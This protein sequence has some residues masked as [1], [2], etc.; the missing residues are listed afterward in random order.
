MKILFAASECAPFVKVGGLADV[1]GSLPRAL[2][3]LGADVSIV[4]PYYGAIKLD[5]KPNLVKKNIALRFE[6]KEA[7]FNL[8]QTELPKTNVSVFLIENSDYFEKGG[9]YIENDASSG[10]SI[11]EARRFLFFSLASVK[12]AN[13]INAN[14]LH[15]HDWHTGLIPY[16]VKKDDFPLKTIISIHNIGYQGVYPSQT[17]NLL[18]KTNFGGSVNCL[19][20]GIINA[21]L[22]TTV[23]Q[24]YAQEILT[25]EF[26][27]GLENDLKSRKKDLVGILNGLDPDQFN[28]QK[29]I[30]IKREFSLKNFKGKIENKIH[31][32]KICFQKTDVS[33]P[34]VG[35]VSRLAQQKGFDLIKEIFPKLMDAKMQ[36][37]I[38][39]EGIKE[40]QDFLQSM[41]PKF[42]DKFFVKIGFDEKFAHQIY[43]GSDI[44]LMPS[45]YEPCG[46]GQMI[47][48]RYGAVPIVRS[49]GGLKDTVKSV[50][51]KTKS[52]KQAI[53][54]TGFLFKEYKGQKLL[55]AVKKALKTFENKKIWIQVQK[56]AMKQDFSWRQSAKKYLEIYQRLTS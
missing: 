29:N 34:I 21:D 41:A 3:E 9:V 44:F 4:L 5:R 56:N 49:V 1:I 12:T 31:L 48:M 53:E 6:E 52:S 45:L 39:G 13:L 20:E 2:K 27:F 16:L 43:A 8:W 32:Q 24:N 18:L 23:S 17:A 15:C 22:I 10:G 54:G 50:K 38:L 36:L 11:I 33:V 14:I 30:Y 51:I 19:R 37:I 35:M 26:G 25:S 28:P 55:A 7:C 40:Y 47:A 46:L 42:S